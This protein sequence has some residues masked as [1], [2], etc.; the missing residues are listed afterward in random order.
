MGSGTDETASSLDSLSSALKVG[1]NLLKIVMIILAIIFFFSNIYWVPEGFVAVQSRFGNIAGKDAGAIRSPGGPYLALPFP[2]DKIARIPTTIQKT[3]VY[4]A[5][6]SE[7][8]DSA[9]I[10]DDRPKTNALRPG[11]HGSLVTADKNIVQGVWVIHY[12]LDEGGD[13]LKAKSS[14]TAFINNVGSMERAKAFIRRIAQAAIVR[15]VSQTNVADF[16]AGQ[17]DNPEIGRR[18]A[19]RLKQLGTGLTV[20]SVASS[21]YAVPKALVPDF[22]AVTQAESQKALAIEKASRQ[23]VSALNELA[24]SGWQDML[25]TI[26]N[27][28][29]ALQTADPTIEPAAFE[30]V[31]ALLLAGRIGGRVKQLLDEARSEK[32]TTIQQARASASRFTELLPAYERNPGV[33]ESQLVQDTIRTIWSEVGVQALYMPKGQKLFLDL[34][35]QDYT[36]PYPS[37]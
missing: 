8:D 37:P 9:P 34:G 7:T 5:F 30:A 11:V 10:I 19:L 18:I 3:V 12:K 26:D 2:L 21:Q 32:T 1:F 29:Q 22:Q 35:Q 24:G 16:V 27:D 15:V 23:R 17:I 14:A 31:E 33:L 13:M 4:N 36:I 28:E 20:T 6:W 25:D